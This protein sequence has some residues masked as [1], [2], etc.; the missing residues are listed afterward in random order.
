MFRF[1]R[2]WNVEFVSGEFHRSTRPLFM[3]RVWFSSITLSICH[4]TRQNGETSS[5]LENSCWWSHSPEVVLKQCL[6]CGCF[7]VV[8]TDGNRQQNKNKSS[9]YCIVTVVELMFQPSAMTFFTS[10]CPRVR[11]QPAS[12]GLINAMCWL[13]KRHFDFHYTVRSVAVSPVCRWTDR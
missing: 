10:I 11:G 12:E 7:R 9:Y 4:P 8:R 3:H 5:V 6:Q 1:P 2:R 13:V